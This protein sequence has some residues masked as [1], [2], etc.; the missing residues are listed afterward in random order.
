MARQIKHHAAESEITVF[1]M[2]VQNFGKGFNEFYSACQNKMKFVRSRPYE[3]AVGPNG[4]VKVKYAHE[5]Q[6]PPDKGTVMEDEFDLVILSVGIRPQ[7]GTTDLAGKLGI[8]TD[9]HGFL[10]IKGASAFPDLQREG[11]YV[12]GTSESPKD[13][14]GCIGQAEAVS[15]LLIAGS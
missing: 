5:G 10:G 14:A 9:E 13:I 12:I 6:P 11:V 7:E 2:D 1:Y 3:F 4:T 8:P 15:A